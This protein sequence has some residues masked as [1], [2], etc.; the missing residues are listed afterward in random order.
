MTTASRLP[1]SSVTCMITVLFVGSLVIAGSF[2]LARLPFFTFFENQQ[3]ILGHLPIAMTAILFKHFSSS[4]TSPSGCA[5]I[6]KFNLM[7]LAH[8]FS[9]V[10]LS[11]FFRPR[12]RLWHSRSFTGPHSPEW[13]AF[14]FRY[15]S[16]ASFLDL[17][18]L[19]GN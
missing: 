15:S 16:I 17:G 2:V 7:N 9:Y 18:F 8:T 4:A 5:E 1:K 12:P 6:L 13:A 10:F 14:F 11:L 19:P 3:P